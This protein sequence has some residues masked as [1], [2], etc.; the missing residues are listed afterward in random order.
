MLNAA[1]FQAIHRR[2]ATIATLPDHADSHTHP[3]AGKWR[4]FCRKSSQ[5][6]K[7]FRQRLF[8]C[9]LPDSSPGLTAA[10]SAAIF[11]SV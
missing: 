9:A 7:L 11:P 6:Q 10:S 5:P 3:A 8:F 4:G 2:T 1:Q